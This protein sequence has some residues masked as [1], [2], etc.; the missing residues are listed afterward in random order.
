M[1]RLVT[2]AQRASFYLLI[3]VEAAGGRWRSALCVLR[4]CTEV[5][6]ILPVGCVP[7]C[8]ALCCKPLSFVGVCRRRACVPG[9]WL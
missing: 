7:L 5:V 4:N 1:G 9:L 8:T 6:A 3:Y 2:A